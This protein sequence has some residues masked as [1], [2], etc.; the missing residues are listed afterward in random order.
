MSRDRNGRVRVAY[1]RAT[2]R[3]HVHLLAC[4]VELDM[5]FVYA[6]TS[7]LGLLGSQQFSQQRGA[8]GGGAEAVKPC[9][10]RAEIDVLTNHSRASTNV[11]ENA[12][13]RGGVRARS[14][15]RTHDTNKTNTV[16]N[17][18][19]DESMWTKVRREFRKTRFVNHSDTVSRI[20]GFTLRDDHQH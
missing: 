20:N 16:E 12:P 6:A 10:L 8:R 14:R 1:G 18:A 2:L 19:T 15:R 17:T 11:H 13:R 3:L 9:A 5:A 7:Q 4:A